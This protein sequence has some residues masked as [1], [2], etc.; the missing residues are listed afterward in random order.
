MQTAEPLVPGPSHLEVENAI[1]KLKNYK[2]PCSDQILAEQIQAGGET[3]V[4][5]QQTHQF[6]VE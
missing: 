5:D 4:C 1:A 6:H 2:S 3:L